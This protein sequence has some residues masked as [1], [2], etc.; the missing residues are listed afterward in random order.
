MQTLD[1][2]TLVREFA[3]RQSEAAFETL[4]ARH[5]DLVYSAAV[6]QVGDAHLAEEVT[7]AVFI[8]LAR[9]AGSLRDGILLIGW[10][11]KTTRYA[12]SAQRRANTRRQR[13]E[14]EA[15]METS[16]LETPAETAWPH[17]APLLDEALAKLNETDR[18]AVL[19]RYFEGRTLAEV[20][21]TLA[22]N[23]EAARKR[24]TRGLE[25]LR[26][27]FVKRG[28][29]LTATVIASAVAANS[30]QAAPVGLAVTVK[31]A[32]LAAAGTGT[33]TLLQFM[34]MTKVKLGISALVVAGATT[35][36]VV[37]HQSQTK[38]HKENESLMQQ[39]TQL[40]TDNES[41]SN[42]LAE[43]NRNNAISLD[44]LNELLKLRA[45]VTRLRRENET[46]TAAA[47]KS[48]ADADSAVQALMNTPPIKTF[49]SV[50][51]DDLAWNEAIITGG[52]KTP[53]G[54]R[55]FH[56]ASAVQG[57]DKEGHQTPLILSRQLEITEDACERL[58]LKKFY[59][60]G[61]TTF[62]D[63]KLTKEQS[64]AIMDATQKSDGVKTLEE[65]NALVNT[66]DVTMGRW[67]VSQHFHKHQTPSG[68]EYS[69]GSAVLLDS[70]LSADGQS[71]HLVMFS[72]Y[73]ALTRPEADIVEQQGSKNNS[74]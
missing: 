64:S 24:V 2:M 37:Q 38:L 70:I 60:E 51:S 4:V 53:S 55:M 50:T 25:K 5:L 36:L 11:F 16:T 59:R 42:R 1:D 6:R 61:Q 3:T 27:Y 12:A 58:G 57:T 10:L 47:K 8:L 52:W 26:K 31:A 62:F 30:V 18:R 28:V 72:Q 17:I 40:Q 67:G 41:I 69:V 43:A 56:I 7:Q 34:T 21:A 29:T 46:V 45:D 15:H 9:K 20:G 63:E 49:A 71:V 44:E 39:L 32:A 22:L 74:K 48:Q 66:G 23:E 35:A 14:T 19:L 65:A 13:L 73:N 68:D 33:F 54:K